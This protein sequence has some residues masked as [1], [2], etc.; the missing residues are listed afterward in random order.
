MNQITSLT[1]YNIS[2][3]GKMKNLLFTVLIILF[4]FNFLKL[5]AQWQQTTLTSEQDYYCALTINGNNIYSGTHNS[6]VYRSTDDGINWENIFDLSSTDNI[7]KINVLGANGANV[8]LGTDAGIYLSRDY[9]INWREALSINKVVN[10]FLINEANIFAGT[11]QGLYL[12]TNNGVS[13]KIVD[14][15]LTDAE[16]YSLGLNDIGIFAGVA[17]YAGGSFSDKGLYLSTDNGINWSPV[18]STKNKVLSIATSETNI[19]AGTEDGGAYLSTDNGVNWSDVNAGIFSSMVYSSA[20]SGNNIYVATQS[21]DVYVSTDFGQTWGMESDNLIFNDVTS[22]ALSEQNIFIGTS[23]CGIWKRPIADLLSKI[24]SVEL[25]Y[26]G[27]IPTEFRLSQN[28]PNPFNP[29]TKIQF[30]ISK[31]CHVLLAIYNTLGQEI[32]ILVNQELSAAS[33]TI[34]YNASRLPSGIYFYKIQSGVYS[35]TKK[36]M[37]VK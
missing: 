37:L 34:D 31:D 1:L 17:G 5:S 16:V 23:S 21:G 10:S 30:N 12:S 2:V 11:S 15:I 4:G 7:F 8:F 3:E 32:E 19:F 25:N 27:I 29:T 18:L 35:S 33:Y 24:T 26:S 36:M 6:K 9:G 22:L 13:W 28:Y 14:N 20:I